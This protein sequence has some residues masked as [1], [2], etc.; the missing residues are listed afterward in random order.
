VQT[1]A[2]DDL[3][4][5]AR[6]RR[7]LVERLGGAWQ[8]GPACYRLTDC[9]PRA[10]H[11]VLRIEFRG[12]REDWVPAY[13]MLPHGLTSLRPAV[14]ALH[15]H[16][17]Q[18]E[19][20][21]SEV[22][23]MAGN[24]AQNIGQRLVEAGFVVLAPDGIAFEERRGRVQQ[25][26]MYERFVAMDEFLHG[27]SLTWRMVGD[28][29]AAA[30]VL[31]ALPQVDARRIG[32]VG[33]SMGGTLTLW[34]AAMDTRIKAA[35]SNC[36]VASLAAVLRDEVIHCYMNYVYGLLP[37]CDHGQVAALIAPRAYLISAGAQDGGFPV[38][39]VRE[40]YDYARR[41]YAALRVPEKLDLHLEDCG[42]AFTDAMHRK[43]L[44]WLRRWLRFPP[45]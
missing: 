37:A 1:P 11:D 33:H 13:L 27:R 12:I 16:A 7:W 22:A 15:Q 17:G 9:W 29:M 3:L 44:A 10:G 20:G 28:C 23:G 14:L 2:P 19:M 45:A 43:A 31:C 32:M 30:D 5:L 21:K 38:D 36:G 24:P 40:T 26:M 6:L 39:G 18:F 4:G 35:V 25:G 8:R 34:A 41:T 42:H